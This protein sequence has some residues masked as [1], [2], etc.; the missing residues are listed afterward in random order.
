MKDLK[1]LGQCTPGPLG[2]NMA[3]YA[4]FQAMGSM[5][6]FIGTDGK[7]YV[8]GSGLSAHWRSCVSVVIFD[9]V[10]QGLKGVKKWIC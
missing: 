10:A 2:L 9:R 4:G 1:L 5:G 6:V 7:R 3:T 8:T